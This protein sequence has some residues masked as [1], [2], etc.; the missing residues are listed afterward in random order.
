MGFVLFYG[1][2]DIYSN[3]YPA[4]FEIDGKVFPTSEH[5]FMYAKAMKFD[6][7]G[8]VTYEAL[9]SAPPAEAKKMGRQ[10]RF[11]SESTWD[12]ID[13][14][15][16]YKACL[17]KFAQNPELK[18][19]ILE[20]GDDIIVECS[21]RDRKWGI[22]MG[23]NNPNAQ[24]PKL[25]RGSN[26]LGETLMKVRAKLREGL[27]EKELSELDVKAKE[28]KEQRLISEQLSQ[29]NTI[30]ESTTTEKPETPE[31]PLPDVKIG[32]T[33]RHRVFKEGIVSD[34]SNGK[35]TVKFSV[36]E[37]AFIFPNAINDGFLSLREI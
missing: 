21:P 27:S 8:P 10:V 34:I 26:L 20:T 12:A 36:G 3:F 9:V 7:D 16:M 22:G 29:Q 32:D 23:K 17:A 24:N 4:S 25:W 33:I 1:I 13:Q 6:P 14:Q 15:I 28:A 5:Y 31:V 11:F 19:Q 2:N 30:H 37:K 18:Q 35:I